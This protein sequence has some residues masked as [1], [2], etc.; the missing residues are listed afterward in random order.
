MD[1]LAAIQQWLIEIGKPLSGLAAASNDASF[2]RYFRG[3]YT[4]NAQRVSYIVMDAPPDKENSA[5][6]C[7]IAHLLELLSVPA[8][9]VVAADLER[10]FLLLTDLGSDTL[11][12]ALSENPHARA[13]LYAQALELLEPLQSTGASVAVENGIILPAYTRK[14]LATEC[15]EFQEWLLERH[16]SLNLTA[17]QID[18]LNSTI[19]LVLD[20]ASAQPQVMVHLDYHSRNLMVGPDGQIS[21]MLDFQDAVIGA[22]TYDAVSLLRDA[23]IQ[24]E[25]D[26]I[27]EWLETYRQQV[28]PNV[29]ANTFTQWFDWMGLQRHIK[30]AGRFC[31][32]N[33]R[34]G[35]SA[36][37]GDIPLTLRYI[38]EVA[39]K[40]PEFEEFCVLLDE[41]VLPAFPES[42][43]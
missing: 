7:D 22:L 30:V 20:S 39:G 16:L 36:Y 4:S 35:K 14:R 40:Y 10:G 41:L 8:T 5:P 26:E 6:F 28:A 37:M 27:A 24:L 21:G 12:T 18:T 17:K 9:R 33:Y 3:W 25:A 1:R 42:Y 31:R 32:L 43:D 23:Y 13:G 19:R 2:R 15:S 38:R 29:D 34:D 11:L